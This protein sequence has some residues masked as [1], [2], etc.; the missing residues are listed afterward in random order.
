MFRA[1]SLSVEASNTITGLIA[2]IDGSLD[3]DS[4]ESV[5][6]PQII[7]IIQRLAEQTEELRLIGM[8]D[9]CLLAAENLSDIHADGKSLSAEHFEILKKIPGRLRT[10]LDESNT[11][12]AELLLEII[13]S[14]P[15]LSSIS[16]KE[17]QILRE[18]LLF[19]GRHHAKEPEEDVGSLDLGR[20]NNLVGQS[21]D[22]DIE[23][24]KSIAAEIERISDSI[25]GLGPQDL[26]LLVRENI[27]DL[28]SVDGSLSA[29]QMILFISWCGLFNKYNEDKNNEQIARAL[30]KNTMSNIWPSPLDKNHAGI[31]A[32]MMHISLEIDDSAVGD[33]PALREITGLITDLDRHDADQ[34]RFLA[35]KIN[36]LAEISG[37]DGLF[38][39]Q[40]ICR[41]LYRNLT[42]S[43][44]K[45]EEPLSDAQ[46]KLVQTWRKLS[47][48][49]LK[50]PGSPEYFDPLVIC[51]SNDDWISPLSDFDATLLSQKFQEQPEKAANEPDYNAL[52]EQTIITSAEII[53]ELTEIKQ[54]VD[55]PAAPSAVDSALVAMLLAEIKNI[56]NDHRDP[57]DSPDGKSLEKEIINEALAQYLFR[58]EKFGNACQA[59]DLNGLYQANNHFKK[60]LSAM[61]SSEEGI[62][63]NIFDLSIRWLLAIENYLTEFAD[64]DASKQ[65]VGLLSSPSLPEPLMNEISPAMLDLLKAPYLTSVDLKK[66]ARL[67]K[68][69]EQDVSIA[70]PDDINQE[71]LD[72]LLQELPD[73]TADFSSAIQSLLE[74]SDGLQAMEK[75]QR[76]AHTIK[77]AANTVGIKGIATL[78][79]Q[80]EDIFAI[81]SGNQRLPSKALGDTLMEAADCLEEM[82]ESLLS[83]SPA[84]A[85][86]LTTL[87]SVL[88][89]VN[90]LETQGVS[91]LDDDLAAADAPTSEAVKKEE[92]AD[93]GEREAEQ[94]LHVPVK[95]IDDLLRLVG[96][97]IIVNTQL[98]EKVAL[99]QEQN[100]LL[101][102]NSMVLKSLTDDIE[103]QIEVSGAE[104][105]VRIGV[106]EDEVFDA[107]ELQKYNVLHSTS[108]HIAETVADINEFNSGIRTGLNDMHELLV[109][110]ERVHNEVHEMIMRT[111]MV[112]VRNIVPRL[113]RCARQTCRATGK[114]VDLVLN[115][116]DMLIDSGMLNTLIDPLMHMIRNAID[117]GIEVSEYRIVSGKKAEGKLELG[118]FTEGA[119]IVIRCRDDG[120]GLELE[121]IRSIAEARGLI[122]PYDDL[123]EDELYRLIL[124]SGFSTSA[125]TTQISGRGIG[126]DV[127]NTQLVAVKGFVHIDSTPGEGTLFELRIPA[128]SMTTHVLLVRSR[129]QLIAIS[130]HG[131]ERI[132]Y[133]D[134]ESR[135]DQEKNR[136]CKVDNETQDI[137]SLEE[138]L[139][140]PPNRRAASRMPE[141]ALFVSEGDVRQVV[142]IQKVED[143]RDVVVKSI[144]KYLNN[145]KGL[146]GST[147]LGDGSVVPV[148]DLPELL[149]APYRHSQDY[150]H[151]STIIGGD[152][153][154]SLPFVLAVDDSLSARRALAQVMKDA[155]YNVRTAKDGLEALAIIEKRPPDIMLVDLEMPRMNGLELTSHIR[156]TEN[157]KD[158]PVIMVTSRST[159]KH[160]QMAAASGVDHYM[161][162]PFSDDEILERV[163]SLLG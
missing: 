27:M 66:E 12:S 124:R 71:L 78:T 38:N 43:C 69:T 89:W 53:G 117:H 61:S 107:L 45:K 115:G 4:P 125:Q 82:T 149:R 162:K 35:E 141:Q 103:R 21:D 139:H 62:A 77:G 75:A 63:Q 113:Q 20:L 55:I 160:R 40:D 80:L 73:Q 130:N 70:L 116:T 41:L 17:K 133:L 59:A 88:D 128:V 18:M 96:E 5:P 129:S 14:A 68:A 114:Q 32:D 76:I 56:I 84:P 136:Q 134:E 31:L 50:N 22:F 44:D 13:E 8:Q 140:L 95:L 2:E 120:R 42:G 67:S 155:G 145:I 108:N 54:L 153:R 91:I 97:T 121:K 39:F 7:E 123:K 16:Q 15:W 81:A 147:I 148:V 11:E 46:Y 126:M 52:N 143:S 25:S 99:S 79:H 154:S 90:H 132:L 65:L 93:V 19:G 119:Q 138:L 64:N 94:L 137:I 110:Q 127:V 85:S 100:R 48:E 26:C 135:A 150:V 122:S 86:S 142:L 159:D 131:V 58:I 111:R 10:Y 3:C 9:L 118:F 106:N 112:P 102:N 37:E 6:I 36:L 83:N 29:A 30:I 49:Y 151:E 1:S 101:L 34:I 158:V 51:M 33:H 144:G 104:Q 47:G 152:L 105:T 109:E 98:Y 60:N 24:L 28:A 87:Q 72:G 57:F 74:G 23:E 156:G 161:I 92:P 146:L 163:Q 157:T